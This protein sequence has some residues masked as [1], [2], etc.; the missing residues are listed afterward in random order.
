[1]K[2]TRIIFPIQIGFHVDIKF[3]ALLPA[4]NI[5]LHSK[6]LEF[7]WLFFAIYVDVA[8]PWRA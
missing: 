2:R 1:M 7:E 6:T 8:K 3:F 5:N 4:L